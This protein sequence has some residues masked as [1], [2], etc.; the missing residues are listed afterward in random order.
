M[1]V[2]LS[3]FWT[4]KTT[5][6]RSFAA[7][8]AVSGGAIDDQSFVPSLRSESRKVDIG[9]KSGVV[10]AVMRRMARFI[11]GKAATMMADRFSFCRQ[12]SS[13]ARIWRPSKLL[14]VVARCTESK[15]K[16]DLVIL[17]DL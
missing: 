6:L 16:P 4:L 15:R 2:R 17:D 13:S 11:A 10:V 1:G 7:S 3:S 8:E 5:P 12:T 14:K 9:R